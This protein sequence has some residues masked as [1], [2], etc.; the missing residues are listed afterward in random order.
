MALTA[1]RQRRGHPTACPCADADLLRRL[2]RED[3]GAVT[4]EMVNIIPA[5][6]TLVMLL[7]QATLWWHASHI[8]QATTA[9]ALAATRV[10]DGTAADGHNQ[11]QRILDQLGR[12]PLRGVHVNVTR[13][14]E[15][16]D[17]RITGTA[18]SVIPFLHLPVQAHAAGPVERFR[19]VAE[20]AP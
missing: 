19:T 17:V 2:W 1:T 14:A 5:L 12:G 13:G 20:V 9:H 11:A 16:A 4:V 18:S 15:R 3:R 8:A 7:A 6:F 10:E